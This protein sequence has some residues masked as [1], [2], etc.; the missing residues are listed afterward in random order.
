M[1]KIV[2]LCKS[3]G[4]KQVLHDISLQVDQP[5]VYGLIGPNGAG[6][7]TLM[8]TICGILKGDSG[9]IHYDL[10][11]SLS[12]IAYMPDT[13]GL[14]T[15]MTVADE[16]KYMGQLRGL[17]AAQALERASE[18]LERLGLIR[19]LKTPVGALSKG[20]MRKV[21]FIC[22]FLV[23]PFLAILDEPFSGLDPISAIEMEKIILEKK[24]QG[25]AVFL[26][27]HHMEQAERF[28]D[29][30]FLINQG[31]LLIDDDLEHLKLTHLKNQYQVESIQPIKFSPQ[32]VIAYQRANGLH[33]YLL[34]TGDDY[35]YQQMMSDIGTTQILSLNHLTPDLKEIFVNSVKS[36]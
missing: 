10:R 11:H 30:I 33:R 34:A 20:T 17:T 28:C 5:L 35:T 31:R 8:R 18:Y 22:T 36:L 14:Y 9:L 7:T 23:Q 1:L 32:R 15:D 25:V 6:K 3:F 16:I 27:T 4:R 26:S 13:T 2:D 19:Y 21:Q 24:R 29:H 12:N